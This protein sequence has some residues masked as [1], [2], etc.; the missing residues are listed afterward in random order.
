MFKYDRRYDFCLVYV[1]NVYKYICREIFD[2]NFMFL[3]NDMCIYVFVKF[4]IMFC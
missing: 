2:I 1:D 4:I 3:D